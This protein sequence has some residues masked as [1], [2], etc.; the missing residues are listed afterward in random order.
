MLL[1]TKKL[2][3]LKVVLAFIA[4]ILK[5]SRLNWQ[6]LI[7]DLLLLD[8]VASTEMSWLLIGTRNYVLVTWLLRALYFT[9]H[10]TLF[11]DNSD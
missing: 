10:C 1:A 2:C 9:V 11:Q 4:S 3:S 8:E 5:N 6:D 7:S